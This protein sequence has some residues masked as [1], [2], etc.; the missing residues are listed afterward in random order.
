METLHNR[1]QLDIGHGGLGVTVR[2]GLKWF[3]RVKPGDIL[4]VCYCR[5]YLSNT[6][7]EL[8]HSIAYQARLLSIWTGTF[9]N[10]PARWI[11]NEH[12]WAARMYSG[13]LESMQRVYED[14]EESEIVT[15]LLYRRLDY[16]A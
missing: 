6:S 11:E 12:E 13:L 14:F 16:E 15:A 2:R 8:V 5:P 1:H 4:A 3:E 7:G 9:M 10:L